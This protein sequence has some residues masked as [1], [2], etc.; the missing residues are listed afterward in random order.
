[1][2]VALV[3]EWLTVR[4]GSEMQ[5]EAI[6]GLYPGAPVHVLVYD[7]NQ[8]DGSLCDHRIVTSFIDSLPLARRRYRAY[9]PLFPFA[10]EQF[11]LSGFD[12]VISSSHAAAKGVL[13]GADQLHLCYC[14]TPTRYVWD[15][16]QPY[17]RS[18]GLRRGV[19]SWL[20]RWLLH[21]FRR[22]DVLAANRVDAF[23][24][25]SHYVA[26]RIGKTYRRPAHVIHPGVDVD[27]FKP[28]RRR[29][30][31]Y[32]AVSRLVPYKR[33]DLIA[34]AMTKLDRPLVVIGEGPHARAVAAAGGRCVTMLGHQPDEVVADYMQR[35]RALLFAAD[36]D[37][38]IVP[39]EAQ[40]AGAPVIAYGKGGALETVIDGQ[41]GV[42]FGAQTV[43]SLC[44]AVRRFEASA[45]QFNANRIAEHARQF[46]M[47]RFRRQFSGLVDRLMDRF[48][49]GEPVECPP[50][51]GRT[52]SAVA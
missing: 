46:S 4:G 14:Y 50:S 31:F 33:M 17:L 5:A 1:M 30:D 24:A 28:Q 47:D 2:N 36:E 7:P 41:T 38:G 19:R 23:I 35:C 16:Y 39:V 52:P 27:R 42:F 20:T 21:R 49:R 29:D 6:G 43:E 15:L 18:A 11:D 13:T 44:D 9:L 37:F 12:L 48:Q 34:A 10:V 40:A 3:H 45:A 22:W 51:P 8:Y 26:R 25:I 32:L